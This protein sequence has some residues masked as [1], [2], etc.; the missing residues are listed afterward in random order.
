ME[1]LLSTLTPR[2]ALV[3]RLRFGIDADESLTLEQVGEQ[4]HVTRERIRQIEVKALQ[5]LRTPEIHS[6]FESIK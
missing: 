1:R 3:I 2:E 5:K 6:L 4:L